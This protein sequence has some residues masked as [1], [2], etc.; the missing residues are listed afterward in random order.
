MTD[1]EKSLEEWIE[2]E[3]SKLKKGFDYT[4]QPTSDAGKPDSGEEILAGL[5]LGAGVIGGA[6]APHPNPV[7]FEGVRISTISGALQKELVD[8]STRVETTQTG[9]SVIITI[10]KSPRDNPYSFSPALTA[11][12]IEKGD[13]LTVT[14][15]DLDRDVKREAL[16]SMGGTVLEQGKRALTGGAAGLAGLIDAAG[17]L[18]EGVGELAEHVDDLSLP[19]RVWDVID[20]VGGAAEKA[21]REEKRRQDQAQR[22]REEA[23]RA[24]T[25]CPSCGRAYRPDEA[26]RVDCAACGA[27]RGAR[28]G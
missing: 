9:D 20:R 21:Y 13:Q 10:Y 2:E 25:H 8:Q 23:E 6:V 27:P 5:G 3:R 28:P 22:K 17:E 26:D 16:S 15:S 19:K 24:W 11:T 12:M 1:E 14:L 4:P 18:V 7:T